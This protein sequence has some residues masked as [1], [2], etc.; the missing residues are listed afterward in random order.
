MKKIF[1]APSILNAD[2]LHLDDEIKK[3]E[4]LGATYLHLDVMDWH[5][6]PNISFGIPVIE[7]VKGK[8]NMV[9]D[10]HLMISEPKKYIEKFVRAG[11]D[12]LTFHYEALKSDDEVNDLIDFIHSFGVKAGISIKTNTDVKVLLPFLEKID[13][14]LIMSVEPGFGGQKF[15]LSSLEKLEFLSIYK[16]ENN[17]KYLIEVDGG[18][19]NE[20]SKLATKAGAE[21]LVCGSYLFKAKNIKENYASLFEEWLWITIFMLAFL[22]SL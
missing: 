14:I 16:K 4:T 17:L 3:V 12:I 21:I 22:L 11:S 10:V 13:L 19:N 8:Y 6:V 15:L 2:F 9:N 5:C 18:I 20:T 7:S 1:I